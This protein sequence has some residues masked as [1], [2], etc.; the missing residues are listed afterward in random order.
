MISKYNAEISG[1]DHSAAGENSWAKPA[2]P[3]FFG[4]FSPLLPPELFFGLGGK[5]ET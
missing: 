1:G 4:L 3:H 5:D 2:R